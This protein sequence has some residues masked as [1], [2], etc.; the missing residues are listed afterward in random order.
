MS[1]LSGFKKIRRHIRLPDGY[2]LLSFWTSSQ[3]VE[4]D[5]GTT[6][7][8]NKTKWDDASNKKHEHSNKDAL[9]SITSNNITKWNDMSTNIEAAIALKANQSELETHV[10]NN[11]IHITADERTKLSGIATGA[12]KYTHPSSAAG[13]KSSGLYKITTDTSG[14][15]T[16]AAAVTKT[17]ITALGI[18]GTNTTY[19]TGTASVSGLTKLYS[20]TGTSTDG[21]MT[22]AAITE[23][24]SYKEE[25]GHSHKSYTQA[26]TIA[27]SQGSFTIPIRYAVNGSTSTHLFAFLVIKFAN[28][29]LLGCI[30]YSGGYNFHTIYASSNYITVSADSGYI[31][32]SG[33][34]GTYT[35]FSIGLSS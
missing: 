3:T 25:I 7:E 29:I 15:V 22:R 1:I 27:S 34:A 35:S 12:N 19:S 11:A 10:N 30:T 14:H 9:D 5:D 24:L 32:V 2:K 20:S 26:N 23:M 8:S 33:P 17:D 28:H 13:A 18:P 21:T 31:T 4:M 16:G 6:L